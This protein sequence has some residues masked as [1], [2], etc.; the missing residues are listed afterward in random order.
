MK[1]N[2]CVTPA[3]ELPEMEVY[4][5]NWRPV[6]AVTTDDESGPGED[7]SGDDEVDVHFMS[8]DDEGDGRDSPILSGKQSMLSSRRNSTMYSR[9]NSMQDA[10]AD[11]FQRSRRNS[12]VASTSRRNSLLGQDSGPSKGPRR[13][14]LRSRR[15][16]L[17]SMAS[18]GSGDSGN[19]G[20]RSP[21]SLLSLHAQLSQLHV[22]MTEEPDEPEEESIPTA[23]RGV[24]SLAAKIKV[25]GSSFG[26]KKKSGITGTLEMM[27]KMNQ[28][29]PKSEREMLEAHIFDKNID[30]AGRNLGPRGVAQLAASVAK[31]S[32]DVGFLDLS[33]NDMVGAGVEFGK[34]DQHGVQGVAG[35][36]EAKKMVSRVNLSWN[37]LNEESGVI[38]APSL[39]LCVNMTCLD[40][41]SN[42]IGPGGMAALAGALCNMTKLSELNMRYNEI[43]SQGGTALAKALPCLPSLTAL[44]FAHNDVGLDGLEA[45]LP[46]LRGL[47][48][49]TKLDVRGNEIGERGGRH[50]VELLASKPF[51]ALQRLN[52]VCI[53]KFI[54]KAGEKEEEEVSVYNQ[55][56][57]DNYEMI[58]FANVVHQSYDTVNLERVAGY[59]VR[60]LKKLDV[61]R[62]NLEAIPPSLQ[63]LNY[64]SEIDVSHNQLRFIPFHSLMKMPNL[65][66][67]HC[68]GNLLLTLPPTQVANLGGY[69]VLDYLREV[70]KSGER[71]FEADL[72]VIGS[73]NSGKTS[74]IEA[75]LSRDRKA[76]F[77]NKKDETVVAETYQRWTPKTS[78]KLVPELLRIEQETVRQM[79]TGEGALVPEE[80]PGED[81][82]WL[83]MQSPHLTHHPLF[84][85]P[86]A[87]PPPDGKA[88][89]VSPLHKFLEFPHIPSARSPFE[90]KGSSP[91]G[92][93]PGSS[94]K[95][96]SPLREGVGVGAGGVST[97]RSPLPPS[98]GIGKADHMSPL[99]RARRPVAKRHLLHK[100]KPVG[101]AEESDESEGADDAQE[102]AAP[103]QDDAR[104]RF[105]Y[106]I[107]DVP[108]GGGGVAT[109]RAMSTPR[110]VFI[111]TWR[112]KK[113]PGRKAMEAGIRA[114]GKTLSAWMTDLQLHKPGAGVL[115][116]A[117]HSDQVT[118]DEANEQCVGMQRAAQAVVRLL[119][120]W[121]GKAVMVVAREG[122][123][124]PVNCLSGEGIR[125]LRQEAMLMTSAIG[126]YHEEV[127]ALFMKVRDEIVCE[128]ERRYWMGWHEYMKMALD[129][130]VSKSKLT[131]VTRFLHGRG[132]IWY[133][134]TPSK[135]MQMPE[136]DIEGDLIM[137]TVF[138][139]PMW[140]HT[141]IECLYKRSHSELISWFCGAHPGGGAATAD[142]GRLK[143]VYILMSSGVLHRDLVPYIWPRSQSS[144]DFFSKA[145]KGR[146][147]GEAWRS[148][149][150]ETPRDYERIFLILEKLRVM[151][152]NSVGHFVVPHL[153]S[154]IRAQTCDV[155]SI[156]DKNCKYG[157]T[158]SL[159]WLPR[160]LIERIVLEG[161][162]RCHYV[163]FGL[164]DATKVAGGLALYVSG[165]KT[166]LLFGPEKASAAAAS[167]VMTFKASSPSSMKTAVECVKRAIGAFPTLQ[168][169]AVFGEETGFAE[170]GVKSPYHVVMS[171]SFQSISYC[172]ALQRELQ[173][174]DANMRVHL[175]QVTEL[176]KL[177]G[178]LSGSTRDLLH[179]HGVSSMD[180][181]R[182]IAFGKT[183][184]WQKAG[185]RKLQREHMIRAGMLE[186]DIQT[187]DRVL[188]SPKKE[189]ICILVCIDDLYQHPSECDL[190]DIAYYVSI[191]TPIVQ[192]IMPSDVHNGGSFK[193]HE[194]LAATHEA[195]SIVDMRG[196][197][198]WDDDGN[199]VHINRK[200]SGI[201]RTLIPAVQRILDQWRGEV[202]T[203]VRAP[204]VLVPCSVCVSE[205]RHDGDYFELNQAKEIIKSNL[206]DR[207]MHLNLA[208]QVPRHLFC[209][210]GHEE[211]PL[212]TIS[213]PIPIK[214]V[215]CPSCMEQNI[216]PPHAFDFWHCL[217]LASWVDRS[218]DQCN[219][220]QVGPQAVMN[221][222]DKANLAASMLVHTMAYR[223]KMTAP[224]RL[225]R[226]DS[227]FLSEVHA[228][229]NLAPQSK[230][231]SSSN[232]LKIGGSSTSLVSASASASSSPRNS[233]R[234]SV[235][236]SRDPRGDM[237]DVTSP[238]GKHVLEMHASSSGSMSALKTQASFS[239]KKKESSSIP[240]SP[241]EKKDSPAQG[242]A[243]VHSPSPRDKNARSAAASEPKSDK[244]ASASASPRKQALPRT[245]SKKRS[246]SSYTT[247]VRPPAKGGY[248]ITWRT[249][250]EKRA[251]IKITAGLVSPLA[252]AVSS[253]HAAHKP[254]ENKMAAGIVKQITGGAFGLVRG[255]VLLGEVQGSSNTHVR[256]QT[257]P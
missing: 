6:T 90:H 203:G 201:E 46:H 164:W 153:V 225:L 31:S 142:E 98:T 187:I 170:R 8:D 26:F 155:R 228:T 257:L 204:G 211:D 217:A 55:G 72:V 110:C 231:G 53:D 93:A 188:N 32:V 132:L 75:I 33:L 184:A 37:S 175:E 151:R 65:E 80:T 108:H 57:M 148:R 97:T 202:A 152:Q 113:Y 180:Q 60:M 124:V 104:F 18:N 48:L 248:P 253:P 119:M 78:W 27:K 59:T 190:N 249:K 128:R 29:M 195:C 111:F 131:M 200:R 239:A 103:V 3:P 197:H 5:T 129:T 112:L 160:S 115:L 56:P 11:S 240:P 233:R 88:S 44:D 62:C 45:L 127:P 66:A 130:G 174:R 107:I 118:A 226:R 147:G 86:G 245:A 256:S 137:N 54:T 63:A 143:E 67:F 193:I 14:S 140:L 117:T 83:F 234:S 85:S 254:S 242:T 172:E 169:C 9:R 34:I 192:V 81:S 50:L 116:A 244:G 40:L 123:S 1:A 243:K 71:D 255:K 229:S 89:A 209:C 167:S 176:Q 70:I 159:P 199:S 251:G 149:V 207:L 125:D 223:S 16:S 189:A 224:P 154:G 168:E 157:T 221:K 102:A 173:S 134:G 191:G 35:L 43:G 105:R 92:K 216:Y 77:I 2:R 58:F 133:F 237:L 15:N 25:K 20:N 109:V 247:A 22:R 12:S 21:V 10:A 158:M 41:Y 52:E 17:A 141:V 19:A 4:D 126:W 194:R 7:H 165:D 183:H 238:T 252:A 185:T 241:R 181:V 24:A 101:V 179:L 186:S 74:V 99:L 138:I 38:L 182:E 156:D 135:A 163:D 246:T 219:G 87:L 82:S 120:T 13:N 69:E 139:S 220:H 146:P 106:N 76:T 49:L 100:A 23:R 68:E 250:A 122:L 171:H 161:M 230:K 136:D 213:G 30:F 47:S 121:A 61:S 206:R 73:V 215:G 235:F 94:A 144:E 232:L 218:L 205:G 95:A 210:W 145:T 212:V 36:L 91:A 166:R 96:S 51:P 150:A 236:G 198:V 39:S 42:S 227:Q 222:R 28:E 114:Q 64:L 208:P 84:K 214:A 178:L 79:V 196:K 177:L 162:E